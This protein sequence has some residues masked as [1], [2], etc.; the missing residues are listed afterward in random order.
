MDG[1]WR[2]QGLMCALPTIG[3][4][5]VFPDKSRVPT[6]KAMEKARLE[7]FTTW[8][9]DK[10]RG[11]GAS[12]KKV[13]I[14]LSSRTCISLAISWQKR[15]LSVRTTTQTMTWLCASTAMCP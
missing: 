14:L 7:T 5:F 1:M 12:S 10:T 4:R 6:S 11:H 3:I 8:V 15:V 2:Q 13:G 9:H